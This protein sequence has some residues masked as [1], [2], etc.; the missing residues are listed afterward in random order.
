MVLL[1]QDFVGDLKRN[2]YAGISYFCMQSR[3][4]AV[5]PLAFQPY[6][7]SNSLMIHAT[8]VGITIL[9]F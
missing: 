8:N 5:A 2:S 7:S 3:I 1:L 6:Q 9:L 4:A